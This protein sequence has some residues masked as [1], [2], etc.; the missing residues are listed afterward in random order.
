MSI[1][2]PTIKKLFAI[3]GSQCAIP[4]CKG[5]LIVGD[6]VVGEICHIRA[7]RK[8]GARYDPL[9]SAAEKDHYDNLILLCS[10][11]HKLV[12]A[13]A[14]AY[15]VDWLRGLKASQEQKAPRPLEHSAADV[16]HALMMLEKH[17]AKTRKTRANVEN[18]TV[19]GGIRASAATGGVSVAIGGSNQA[20]INIRTSAPKP[21]RMPYP[22]NSIGADANMTNYVE[23]L[24][25]LYVEYMRM[26]EPDEKVS[27]KKLGKHIKTRF[28]LR[29]KTRN[30]L[31]AERFPD[32]VD[33][34]IYEKL[35]KTPVGTKHLRLGT[36]LCRTFEE[37]RHGEM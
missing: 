4:E 11:C 5:P 16:Q 33:F 28:R 15:P 34:L 3:S 26:I 20:P 35:V 9:L 6:V 31:S 23:Y 22:P 18:V 25:G 36:R 2:Q 1:Q 29:K 8:G 21:S 7:R 10:T 17:I 37:F 14:S 27:W 30:H 24:C 12:D 19:L 32:L 13:Q